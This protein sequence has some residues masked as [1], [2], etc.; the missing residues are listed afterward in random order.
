ME[1][2]CE[3]C[4]K[5]EMRVSQLSEDH[6]SLK[7]KCPRCGKETDVLIKEIEDSVAE[8][9]QDEATNS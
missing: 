1:M 8:S 9:A 6:K 2:K 4:Q 5:V 7:L 3:T